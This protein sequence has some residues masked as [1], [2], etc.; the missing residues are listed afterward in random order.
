[1]KY[2]YTYISTHI[3]YHT[4]TWCELYIYKTM[5]NLITYYMIKL[6]RSYTLQVK[7]THTAYISFKQ[8]Y[9]DI[10]NLDAYV[11]KCD[12]VINVLYIFISLD[13]ETEPSLIGLKRVRKIG[14][15]TRSVLRYVTR[16]SIGVQFSCIL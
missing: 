14:Y 12:V 3:P 8:C 7:T 2:M 1:M 6:S 4:C 11:N 13:F 9:Q 5:D 15:V 10:A 16:N